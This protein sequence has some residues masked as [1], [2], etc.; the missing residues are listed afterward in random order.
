M[1][2]P[3]P[4]PS[5]QAPAHRET[6][7]QTVPCRIAVL[8][9]E[10]A[11][12]SSLTAPLDAFRVAN[13]LYRRTHPGTPDPFLLDLVN[14]HGRREVA[15]AGGLIVGGLG[16]YSDDI[17][18]LIVPGLEYR[19]ADDLVSRIDQLHA[20]QELVRK[21]WQSGRTVAGSCS[22][23]FLMAASGVLDGVRA[24][25]SWWLAP[26]FA[27]R[28]PQV[29]LDPQALVVEL[30]RRITA[31]AVTAMFTVVLRLIEQ[32][33]GPELAQN[34]AR[35]LLVDYERQSQA[36]FVVEALLQR[37][38]TPFS[39]KIERFL[40]SR[41]EQE[42]SIEDLAA[43]CAMSPRTLLRR[44][45]QVY[46]RSPQAYVQELRVERAKALLDSTQLSLAEVVE[47]CGYSDVASFRKL[48]K[49]L[50]ALTPADYR[51]RFRM[52]GP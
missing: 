23:T 16:R 30:E 14:A 5:A 20:E 49:R 26:A 32:R 12:A 33:M 42:F 47:Q 1:A 45:Q 22:G 29:Q 13:A 8:A 27:R 44:F 7:V 11:L 36:P 43:H 17:D 28:F 38:R 18:V 41:L 37:P 21:A 46:H 6:P 25:T 35:V 19:D 40:R 3:P 51:E 2:H 24:T 52:R 10:G 39:E 15:A 34:T 50:T 31:G 9:P 4:H 48:F